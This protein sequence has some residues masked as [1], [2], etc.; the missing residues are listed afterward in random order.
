LSASFLKHLS[1]IELYWFYLI[2]KRERER[3]RKLGRSNDV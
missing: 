3:E 2:P 1:V